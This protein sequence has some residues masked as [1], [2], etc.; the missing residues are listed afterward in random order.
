VFLDLASEFLYLEVVLLEDQL[1]V[2]HLAHVESA[3]FLQGLSNL[4][5]LLLD[6]V[7]FR[8]ESKDLLL[9]LVHYGLCHVVLFAFL[10]IHVLVVV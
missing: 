7:Q 5:L 3:L 8:L 10:P 9:V 1:L 4:L 2:I 6:V